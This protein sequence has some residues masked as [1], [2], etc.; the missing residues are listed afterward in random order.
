MA[1]K[2]TFYPDNKL[3]ETLTGLTP[4][5]FDFTSYYPDDP[6]KSLRVYEAQ[7]RG[8]LLAVSLGNSEVYADAER[9]VRLESE[10]DVLTNKTPNDDSVGHPEL[11][12]RRQELESIRGKYG[13]GLLEVIPWRLAYQTAVL[14]MVELQ[15]VSFNE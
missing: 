6:L 7:I 13:N 5:T 2:G 12:Q 4:T 3:L 9:T 11:A 10:I 1:E 14:E 15:R 8:R